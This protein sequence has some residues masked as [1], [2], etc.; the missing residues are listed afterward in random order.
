MSH[1]GKDNLLILKTLREF[2]DESIRKRLG[3][4]M[5]KR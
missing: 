4:V 3:A 2:F 5:G 1:K